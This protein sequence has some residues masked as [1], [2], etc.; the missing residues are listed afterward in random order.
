MVVMMMTTPTFVAR[1]NCNTTFFLDD[2]KRI[3]NSFFYFKKEQKILF[4]YFFFEGVCLSGHTQTRG[5]RIFFLMMIDMTKKKWCVTWGSVTAPKF[6]KMTTCHFASWQTDNMTFVPS[7]QNFERDKKKIFFFAH[8]QCSRERDENGEK[9]SRDAQKKRITTLPM[10]AHTLTLTHNANANANANVAP[11][12]R[13]IRSNIP[14][15]PTPLMGNIHWIYFQ[16]FISKNFIQWIFFLEKINL[17][18]IQE[19]IFCEFSYLDFS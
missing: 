17:G 7:W 16:E 13:K 2:T 1:G 11:N 4:N 18:K 8:K 3:F 10:R 6:I 9:K 15:P 19:C 5:E 12:G 14:T